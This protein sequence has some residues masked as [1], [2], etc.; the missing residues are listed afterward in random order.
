[1]RP[2]PRR[3]PQARRTL[4]RRTAHGALTL[5]TR[6]AARVR[7]GLGRSRDRL[8]ADL[9]A[10]GGRGTRSGLR[11]PRGARLDQSG[12]DEGL[13]RVELA[14]GDALNT[15]GPDT[16]AT[17]TATATAGEQGTTLGPGDPERAPVC[18][19]TDAQ[20]V[21]YGAPADQ[22]NRY[23][24]VVTQIR[25]IMRRANA[26]LNSESLEAG[27]AEADYRM[28]CGADDEIRV[29]TF[30]GPPGDDSFRAVVDAAEAAGF[31][32]PA[33]KYTIFY[34]TEATSY[35]GIASLYGDEN[36]SAANLNNTRSFLRAH[37]RRVLERRHADA[38][39]RSQHGCG[40]AGR[41]KV[42]RQRPALLPGA[43]PHVLLARRRRP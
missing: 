26:V 41:S 39:E 2:R 5:A 3:P 22:A 38:R 42:D 14:D 24:E 32:D 16:T 33:T 18:A 21:L 34:E 35:C 30:T 20:H 4:G 17:A 8:G 31:D 15:H 25:S 29:D 12:A 36:L 11:R 1:M 43:R 28:R 9:R 23:P 40:A 6:L 7:R 19:T 10:G 27:G 37:P 13:F